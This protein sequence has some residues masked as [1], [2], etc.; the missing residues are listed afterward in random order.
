MAGRS[1]DAAVMTVLDAQSMTRPSGERS[2]TLLLRAWVEEESLC[3]LRVRIIRIHPRGEPSTSV[4]ASVETTC[5]IVQDWLHELL[6]PG[7]A[8]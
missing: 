7:S 6:R 8:S 1:R 3:G 4:V 2:A 5:A